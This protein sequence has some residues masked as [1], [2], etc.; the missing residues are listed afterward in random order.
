MA[1]AAGEELGLSVEAGEG[2]IIPDQ[3]VSFADLRAEVELRAND[4]FGD[5]IRQGSLLP[6]APTLC[7]RGA[8][9]DSNYIKMR[10]GSSLEKQ[11]DIDQE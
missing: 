8:G 3:V 7:G 11:W 1:E 6:Q 10:V 4:L 2:G 9:N 5:L